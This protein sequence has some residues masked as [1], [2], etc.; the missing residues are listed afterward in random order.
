MTDWRTTDIVGTLRFIGWNPS[1][2]RSL[3]TASQSNI[4]LVFGG[5]AGE[6]HGIQEHRVR[7]K[8]FDPGT[9]INHGN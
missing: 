5:M 4:D 7:S 6:T 1:R 3:E 2:E 8:I 9:E